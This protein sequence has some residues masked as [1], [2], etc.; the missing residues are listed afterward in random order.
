[1]KNL[2]TVQPSFNK[3]TYLKLYNMTEL[4][5]I[6]HYRFQP[7][8]NGEIFVQTFY[9]KH[10]KGIVVLIHG[11]LDHAGALQNIISYL[12]SHSYGVIT[13][14][15]PGHGHSYGPRGEIQDFSEYSKVLEEVVLPAKEKYRDIP[16]FGIGHSTG[17]S[18]LI[19]NTHHSSYSFQKI[20]LVAPLIRPYLWSFSELGVKLIRNRIKFIRRKFRNNSAN[21]EYLE[22][23]KKDPLQFTSLPTSWLHSL[24]KWNQSLLDYSIKPVTFYIIQGNRDKTVDWRYNISFIL[25]KY[26]Q[27]RATL[28]DGG[29]HQLFNE[30]QSIQTIVLNQIKTILLSDD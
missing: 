23:V 20:I 4:E 6:H 29:D 11:Y 24:S 26:P 14:D 2:E 5:N 30:E 9:P 12:I 1:M 21:K 16:F 28:I 13:F 3:E 8:K 15:L 22:F 17:A 7:Y 25:N 10:M 18:I 19:E 27:S